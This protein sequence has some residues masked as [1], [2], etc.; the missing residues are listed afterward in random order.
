MGPACA[1]ASRSTC[2]GC[3]GG[4]PAPIH[5]AMPVAACLHALQRL[6]IGVEVQLLGG[7]GAERTSAAAGRALL[8]AGGQGGGT[9]RRR[10]RGRSIGARDSASR[11]G[12][13]PQHLCG[14]AQAVRGRG[15]HSFQALPHAPERC[16]VLARADAILQCMQ[17][18]VCELAMGPPS[19][20]KEAAANQWRAMHSA[21]RLTY[22]LCST[23]AKDKRQT[24]LQRKLLVRRLRLSHLVEVHHPEES[25]PLPE[26][27]KSGRLHA[28]LW[29]LT[30][31]LPSMPYLPST[32]A[33][34][35][36]DTDR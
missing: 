22:V 9:C 18:C 33:G 20:A 4:G 21:A 23:Q 28:D 2:R 29:P 6:A 14:I 11:P 7:V 15:E 30:T 19:W 34:I 3:V 27:A 25:V 31:A 16:A 17:R 32:L 12:G 36:H 24:F 26:A 10:G 35:H 1:A 13:S 8:A 5:A